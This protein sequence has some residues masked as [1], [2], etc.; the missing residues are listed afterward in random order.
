[1]TTVAASREAVARRQA[2]AMSAGAATAISPS[3]V[4]LRGLSKDFRQAW[5][6]RRLRVL[7]GIDLTVHSGEILGFIGPNGAG[8]TTT[9]KC[10]LGLLRPTGGSVR[11][12]GAPLGVAERA[13]IGFLPEQPYFYDYLTVTETLS[14]YASLYGLA[15]AAARRRIEGVIDLVGLGHQRRAALRTLSKGTM[16]RLG[17]AQAILNQPRLLIL[18]E[19]MSGLD[20]SGRH[21]MRELIRSL[22]T[23]GTTVIFSSHILPDA[24][25]LCDRVAI[26]SGGRLSEVVDLDRA[27]RADLYQLT[28]GPLAPTV[29]ATLEQL[30][31]T[32]AIANHRG[33]RLRLP[34][35][36][37]VG[38]ALD[39]IRSAGGNVESLVPA[40]P[41]LEDRFLAHVGAANDLE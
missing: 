18:D 31:G 35:S 29:L 25:V 11:F 30:S 28:V 23:S 7:D 16:Q 10:I 26:L 37:A 2:I 34:G 17:I 39:L 38:P 22:N 5:R 19:P 32:S 40:H 27:Q 33:W 1:M 24:E 12:A 9:F 15:G 21:T 36:E 13:A 14:L 20:P 8:K 41:S 4:E 3:L 6:R